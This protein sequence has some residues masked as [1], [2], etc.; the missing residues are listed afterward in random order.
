ML[1][2]FM[3]CRDKIW[4]WTEIVSDTCVEFLTIVWDGC[5]RQLRMFSVQLRDTRLLECAIDSSY[6]IP[7]S[8][9][10]LTTLTSIDA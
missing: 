3:F 4:D 10:F 2:R 8:E 1:F 7:T 6:A 5:N 9:H